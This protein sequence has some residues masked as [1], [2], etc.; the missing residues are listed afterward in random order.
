MSRPHQPARRRR[1]DNFLSRDF[2]F[3]GLHLKPKLVSPFPSWIVIKIADWKNI[4]ET[5]L[6]G[7]LSLIKKRLICKLMLIKSGK[8]FKTAS[9]DFKSPVSHVMISRVYID[10]QPLFPQKQIIS[11]KW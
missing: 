3:I 6:L 10:S 11:G 7:T 8:I 9:N 5:D 1:A 4:Y 2:S